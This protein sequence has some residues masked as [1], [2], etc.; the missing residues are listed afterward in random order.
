MEAKFTKSSEKK[1]LELVKEL[2]RQIYWVHIDEKQ[3]RPLNRVW[4]EFYSSL[5]NYFLHLV[6]REKPTY[7]GLTVYKIEMKP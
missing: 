7:V 6:E 2:V 1:Y 4:D 5:E 3:A